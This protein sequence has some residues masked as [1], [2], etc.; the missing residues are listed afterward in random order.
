MKKIKLTLIFILGIIVY[1]PFINIALARQS[2]VEVK[3]DTPYNWMVKLNISNFI[4][5][6]QDTGQGTVSPEL[7]TLDLQGDTGITVVLTLELLTVPDN[8]A[9][10]SFFD[11]ETTIVNGILTIAPDY[12][13]STLPIFYPLNYTIRPSASSTNFTIVRGNTSNYFSRP[14]GTPLVVANDLNWTSQAAQLQSRI[15]PYYLRYFGIANSRVESRENGLKITQ[16]ADTTIGAA[17]LSLNYNSIGILESAEGNYGGFTLFSMEY[18]GG[19]SIA[20]ELPFFLSIF[21][22]A[23]ISL[24]IRKRKKLS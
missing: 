10:D 11:I 14:I 3:E 7:M 24:T 12:N 18:S 17:E 16:P 20:F 6:V 4:E 23:L 5:L 9:I 21:A 22:I 19:G 15:R 2:G 13:I 1:S 8:F